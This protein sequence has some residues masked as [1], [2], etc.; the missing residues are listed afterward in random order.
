MRRPATQAKGLLPTTSVPARNKLDCQHQATA[1]QAQKGPRHGTLTHKAGPKWTG[2]LQLPLMASGLSLWDSGCLKQCAAASPHSA[3][4]SSRL[5]HR[6]CNHTRTCRHS[7]GARCAT[8]LHYLLHTTACWQAH[9]NTLACILDQRLQAMQP[10]L[11]IHSASAR[12]APACCSLPEGLPSTCG[13]SC[14][15]NHH[16]KERAAV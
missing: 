4:C 16:A 14:P 7:I 2:G 3:G 5:N 10:Q 12:R 13:P 8:L 11:P 1:A 15:A 9:P 6:H